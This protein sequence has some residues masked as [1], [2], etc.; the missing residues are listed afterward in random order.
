MIPE[1]RRKY[2]LNKSPRTTQEVTVA[3]HIRRGHDMPADHPLR[4]S[5]NS[6]L[7]TITQVKGILEARRVPH[8]I[9]IYSEGNSA[10]FAEIRI[11]GVELSKY[12]VGHNSGG[13]NDDIGKVSL[14]DSES[15][16]DIDAYCAMRELI[17]ADV[18]IMSKS[19][20]CYYASLISDGIKIFEPIPLFGND[21][22]PSWKCRRYPSTDRWI[23]CLAEGS[24]D[25]VAF[26]R[27][28]FLVIQSK[29]IAGTNASTGAS[30]QQSNDL[31]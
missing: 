20:F 19:S 27:Q 6:I 12:R 21:Y 18:L 13:S 24:F 7:R 5:T 22:M 3:V 11:P 30:D 16:L 1:F 10:D 23:P 28:L 26:E 2:Y 14:P 31:T 4:G 15:F 25:S 9:S 29:S 8:K 17:E